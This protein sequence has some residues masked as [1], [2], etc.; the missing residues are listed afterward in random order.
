MKAGIISGKYKPCTLE[1]VY[2]IFPEDES[3]KKKTIPQK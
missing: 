1:D 2:H 3:K